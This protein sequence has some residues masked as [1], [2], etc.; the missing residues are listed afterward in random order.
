MTINDSDP[1]RP[2]HPPPICAWSY[3]SHKPPGTSNHRGLGG[4]LDYRPSDTTVTGVGPRVWT[5]TVEVERIVGVDSGLFGPD[6]GD[7]GLRTTVGHPG[8]PAPRV[9]GGWYRVQ[10][11]VSSTKSFG[12]DAGLQV[13]DVTLRSRPQSRPRDGPDSR[14]SRTSGPERTRPV[15][16]SPT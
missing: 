14:Y 10:R 15:T 4:T 1:P 7:P 8:S 16:T 9:S 5:K 11:H 13:S 2:T 12:S 6:H 3:E